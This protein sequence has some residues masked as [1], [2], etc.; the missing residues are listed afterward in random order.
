MRRCEPKKKPAPAPIIAVDSGAV[1]AN[2]GWFALVEKWRYDLPPPWCEE[3]RFAVIEPEYARWPI[4]TREVD[5]DRG[6]RRA[7]GRESIGGDAAKRSPLQNGR[8]SPLPS[9]LR[10]HNTYI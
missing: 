4:G 3:N 2:P 7:T 1:C 6:A 9:A 10:C 5:V 8:C